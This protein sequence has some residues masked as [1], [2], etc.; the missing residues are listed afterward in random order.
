[1]AKTKIFS[2]SILHSELLNPQLDKRIIELL[3][4][5]IEQGKMNTDIT[6]GSYQTPHIACQIVLKTLLTEAA[7]LLR[8]N[9]KF[10]KKT[11]MKIYAWINRNNKYDFNKPHIH[12]SN[13]SGI[14]YVQ[15]P[16]QNGNLVFMKNSLAEEFNDNDR[17]IKDFSFVRWSIQPKA[18]QF[19]LFPSNIMHLV[20]PHYEDKPRISVSFNIDFSNG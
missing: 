9:Y 19:I 11:N 5:Y 13:F 3:E 12:K 10:K 1:M 17:Y 8:D 20:E 6:I 15:T 14:Y 2:D 18:N 4:K 7:S 16:K